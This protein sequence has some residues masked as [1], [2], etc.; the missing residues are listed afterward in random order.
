MLNFGSR[1]TG[2]VEVFMGMIPTL[3]WSKAVPY[4]DVELITPGAAVGEKDGKQMLQGISHMRFLNG[5]SEVSG[6]DLS[7]ASANTMGVT[8]MNAAEAEGAEEGEEVAQFFFCRDGVIY[9]STDF[10]S[11]WRTLRKL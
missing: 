3:E 11:F 1:N 6:P 4:V 7:I 2:A 8:T 10:G 5:T 9:F